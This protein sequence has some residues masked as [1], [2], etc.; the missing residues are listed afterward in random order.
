[1]AYQ[2]IPASTFGKQ[3]EEE[4]NNYVF[5]DVRTQEEF[6]DAH[7]ENSIHIPYDEMEHRYEE[8]A[9]YKQKNILLIC[10][11]GMRSQV[12]AQ[13]LAEQGFEK[14]FNLEGGLLEWT[15]RLHS[16]K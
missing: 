16:D 12:A 15:G 1:M 7:V 6:D 4:K 13:I 8:L 10:R 14:L 3:F 9:S 11:S 5:V 2:H